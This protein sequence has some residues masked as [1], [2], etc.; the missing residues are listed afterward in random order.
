MVRVIFLDIDGVLNTGEWLHRNMTFTGSL[1]EMPEEWWVGL[2]DPS[3]VEN[4]NDLI[5][6]TG[7]EVVISSS[8]RRYNDP[9]TLQRVLEGAGFCGKVIGATVARFS[10]T[11]R[12]FAVREWLH[13]NVGVE[14]F[15]ILDDRSDVEPFSAYHVKTEP[16]TGF[17][18]GLVPEAVTILR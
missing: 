5:R 17:H 4:L 7:A 15:V 11:P 3:L 12:G 6:Q 18:I 8:W 2:L 10:S 9:V 1:S 13:E 14:S 16:D